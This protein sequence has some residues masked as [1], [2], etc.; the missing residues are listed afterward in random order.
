MGPQAVTLKNHNLKRTMK[1]N[2]KQLFFGLFAS[3][4]IVAATGC[5]NTAHGA[6]EDIEKM[7]EKIQEKTD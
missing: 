3:L 7:G 4:L 5:K 1:I 6:G 2:L